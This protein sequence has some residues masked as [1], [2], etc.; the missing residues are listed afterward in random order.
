MIF[1]YLELYKNLSAWISKHERV[2]IIFLICKL[3][4]EQFLNNRFVILQ[5]GWETRKEPKNLKIL[6]DNLLWKFC[7][8]FFFWGPKNTVKI[9]FDYAKAMF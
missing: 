5:L 6:Q 4:Y 9:Q 2:F 7:T 3:P 1:D 8:T